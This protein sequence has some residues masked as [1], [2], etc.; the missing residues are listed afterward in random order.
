MEKELESY[1][2]SVEKH[3]KNM[4][5]SERADVIKEL[6]SYM[7]ELQRNDAFSSKK[8]LERLGPSTEL[9]AGYLGD[10]ISVGVSFSFKKLLMVFSF[11]SL[12]SLSG[13]FVIPCG[14]V[15]A[16]GFMLAGIISPIAGVIKLLGVLFQFDTS[17]II[18]EFGGLKFHP[19]LIFLFSFVLG[20]LFLL[21]GTGIWKL[22]IGYIHK[23][24]S[25]KRAAD[26]GG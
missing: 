15:L 8:I 25:L 24:S 21:L 20:A 23:V 26:S 17:Y 3:L 22:V 18:F 9:A 5:L 4:P 1:L 6:K 16:G 11:Y 10:K 19:L 2:T 7:E 12:T 14:T 13:L